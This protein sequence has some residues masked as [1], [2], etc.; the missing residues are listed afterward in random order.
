MVQGPSW[1]C[2]AYYYFI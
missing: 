1:N 2:S